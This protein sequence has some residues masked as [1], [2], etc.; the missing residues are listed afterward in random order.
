L[1]EFDTLK[2]YACM[3]VSRSMFLLAFLVSRGLVTLIAAALLLL[4]GRYIY[5]LPVDPFSLQTAKG[6]VVIAL[7][8]CM[9]MALGMLLGARAKTIGAATLLANMVYFP[10]MF[11]GDL[12]IPLND[13]PTVAKRVVSLIP[14]HSLVDAI[15]QIIFLDRSYW[16][17]AP[18][19]GWVL[20]CTVVF[21]FV[22]RANFHWHAKSA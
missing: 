12:T 18:S 21:F 2:L 6:F 8:S 15:R 7:G 9:F 16:D 1:R 14:V 19:I 3:P 11:L 20:V 10:L 5:G 13:F 4:G 22:A 17:V